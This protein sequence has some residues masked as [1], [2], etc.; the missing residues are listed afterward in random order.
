MS[1]FKLYSLGNIKCY[2]LHF[3]GV[4]ISCSKSKSYL[5]R[6]AD[7]G[8]HMEYTDTQL[9]WKDNS[10]SMFHLFAFESLSQKESNSIS[11]PHS[12]VYTCYKLQ[13]H[14][15]STGLCVLGLLG[16]F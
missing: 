4:S 6:A 12:W 14:L 7:F 11:G 15:S 2:F 8:T 16:C 9:Q 5:K 13:G 3:W 10:L 1:L